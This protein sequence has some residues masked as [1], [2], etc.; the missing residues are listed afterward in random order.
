MEHVQTGKKAFFTS[1][2][3]PF[4]QNAQ[5]YP[6]NRIL[7]NFPIVP[8]PSLNWPQRKP[9]VDYLV[10]LCFDVLQKLIKL[11][12]TLYVHLITRSFLIKSSLLK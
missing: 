1:R 3:A 10:A 5:L 9:Q 6:E 12:S 7:R 4:E 2:D 11:L 8:F